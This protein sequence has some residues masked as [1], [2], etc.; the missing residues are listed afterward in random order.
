MDRGYLLY[1]AISQAY[2]FEFI[3]D[4]IIFF[5]YDILSFLHVSSF[6]FLL[7]YADSDSFIL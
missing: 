3:F 7:H 2:S 5:C 4:F 1:T 6:T